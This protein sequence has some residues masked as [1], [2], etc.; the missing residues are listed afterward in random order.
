MIKFSIKI[1]SIQR[2]PDMQLT[3]AQSKIIG[4]T[5][6]QSLRDRVQNENS[7][8]Y[9]APMESY[10]DRPV[11]VKLGTSKGLSVIKSGRIAI[12]KISALRRA[13]ARSYC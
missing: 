4:N 8:L 9:N 7:D 2:I 12:A 10:S 5:A 1:K 13:G 3:D 6:I 11:Y